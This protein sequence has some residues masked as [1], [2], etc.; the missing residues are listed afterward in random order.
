MAA[1]LLLGAATELRQWAV[2]G[3]EAE[4][5]D[6]L[7]DAA[8]AAAYAVALPLSRRLDRARAAA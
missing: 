5:A 6:L 1:C 8:G 4:L 2:P 7:A 3:R